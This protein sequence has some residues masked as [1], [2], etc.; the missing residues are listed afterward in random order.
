MPQNKIK[1]TKQINQEAEAWAKKL[2][3]TIGPNF[4]SNI[5]DQTAR[6]KSLLSARTKQ[7]KAVATSF[8]KGQKDD[9]AR[10]KKLNIAE[11][12]LDYKQVP[13]TEVDRNVNYT[14]SVIPG[15]PPQAN[16]TETVTAKGPKQITD[17]QKLA[18]V[19][20]LDKEI[21]RL[22]SLKEV[23]E[24][25]YSPEDAKYYSDIN[26]A[27][28]AH[29]ARLI[30]ENNALKNSLVSTAAPDK[31]NPPPKT[32][33]NPNG[34]PAN[35]IADMTIANKDSVNIEL[36]KVKALEALK[37]KAADKAAAKKKK[38]D[39]RNFSP[40]QKTN[41]RRAW[42]KKNKDLIRSN[43]IDA[44]LKLN[45]LKAWEK[46]NGPFPATLKNES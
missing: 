3:Q 22:A 12:K 10:T 11:A 36:A 8:N 46:G 19:A 23:G 43:D 26:A 28:R 35:N 25:E 30:S 37:I 42:A 24:D 1:S 14:D 41:F 33:P 4:S 40:N 45:Q 13:H 21:S 32:N 15:M 6:T 18:R 9:A 34:D 17:Q 2:F 20:A 31:T 5:K 27:K 29:I 7:N 38:N 39:P 16:V 44:K